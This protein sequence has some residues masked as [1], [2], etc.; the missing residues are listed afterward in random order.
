MEKKGEIFFPLAQLDICEIYKQEV[1][2][3]KTKEKEREI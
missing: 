3:M 2:Q 1:N